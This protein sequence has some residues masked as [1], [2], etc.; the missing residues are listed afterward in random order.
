LVNAFGDLVRYKNNQLQA[1]G[2]IE[3]NTVVNVTKVDETFNNGIAFNVDKLL[4]Y[5][6]RVNGVG[7]ARWKELTLWQYLLRAK[8]QNPSGV[9]MFV[10]YVRA[11]L[12]NPDTDDLDGIKAEN[13]YTVLM[14]NNSAM[15][16]AVTRGFLPALATIEGGDLVARAKATQFLNAHFLQGTVLP[17]DGYKFIYPVNPMSPERILAPTILKITDEKLGLTS[18]STRI[19]VTKT[20][21]GLMTFMPQNI[22]LGTRILVTAGFGLTSIMRVQ[23]G[24]VTG[25]TIQ[26]NYRSNRIACKAVLHEVNNFFTF[27]L[28][29]SN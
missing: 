4:Q 16:Q 24:A 2:N 6:P 18:A 1:A 23:R 25:T 8:E 22:T 20:T 10:D 19:E 9:S 15:T 5:S 7:E 26:N 14:V 28:N 13:F 29:S 21:T 12:K 11:C 17:D 3:D 27:T